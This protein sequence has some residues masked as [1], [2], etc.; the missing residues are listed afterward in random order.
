MRT[1][2][3]LDVSLEVVTPSSEA[4]D[5]IKSPAL[6]RAFSMDVELVFVLAM[7]MSDCSCKRAL[8]S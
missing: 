7:I 8:L 6:H 3:E 2:V 5:G 1:D 4:D